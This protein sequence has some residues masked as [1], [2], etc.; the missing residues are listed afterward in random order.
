[1]SIRSHRKKF[2]KRKFKNAIPG[3]AGLITVIANRVGCSWTTAKKTIA[4]DPDLMAM[5]QEEEERVDDMAES[6]LIQRLRNG[7]EGVARWWLTRRRRQ[8]YGDAVDITSGGDKITWVVRWGD[9]AD[10][11]DNGG[12]EDGD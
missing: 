11:A 7:D 3:S 2:S 1:M 4:E 5:L 12:G 10:D 8:R 6:V 9:W